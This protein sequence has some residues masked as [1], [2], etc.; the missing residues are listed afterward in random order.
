MSD[1]TAPSE[2]DRLRAGAAA[3]RAAVGPDA[4]WIPAIAEGLDNDAT[5]LDRGETV[6]DLAESLALADSF[7]EGVVQ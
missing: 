1:Q 7:A 2:A 4:I 6:D 5:R 3:M